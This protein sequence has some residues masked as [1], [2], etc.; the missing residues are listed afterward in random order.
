MKNSFEIN[1]FVAAT[2]EVRTFTNSSLAK[3]SIAV[4]REENIGDSASRVSALIG[5]EMW[6][7]NGESDSFNLLVKGAHLQ[8]SGYFQPQT[9]TDKNGV[10]HNRVVLVATEVVEIPKKEDTAKAG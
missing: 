5:C 9:W 10:K 6:R 4:S 2:A 1:G 3:F 8:V 7:K